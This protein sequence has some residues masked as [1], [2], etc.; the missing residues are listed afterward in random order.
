MNHLD[1]PSRTRASG[2]T[3][4]RWSKSALP[5]PSWNAPEIGDAVAAA[6]KRVGLTER[7][8]VADLA[9]AVFLELEVIRK[10]RAPEVGP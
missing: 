10:A 4:A 5:A 9:A 3:G 6:A 2:R 1:S 8:V 7:R